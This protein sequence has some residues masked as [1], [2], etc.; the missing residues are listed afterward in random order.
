MGVLVQSESYAAMTKLK[1][2]SL[3]VNPSHEKQAAASM[4]CCRMEVGIGQTR[5][6]KK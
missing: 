1:T 3:S 2:D 4:S 5:P 6:F